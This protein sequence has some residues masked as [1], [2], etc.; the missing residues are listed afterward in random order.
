MT[1]MK[2]IDTTPR[3]YVTIIVY[4]V[5]RTIGGTAPRAA[6]FPQKRSPYRPRWIGW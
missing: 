3:P 5:I 6:S 1:I 2:E 4:L